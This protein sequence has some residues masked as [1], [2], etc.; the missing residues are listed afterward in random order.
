[1]NQT[2]A[3]WMP[4]PSTASLLCLSFP[5]ELIHSSKDLICKCYPER[6]V[7]EVLT[8]TPPSFT[9]LRLLV[10]QGSHP[11]LLRVVGVSGASHTPALGCTSRATLQAE[12]GL[13]TFRA[14]A[15]I[16]W[17]PQHSKGHGQK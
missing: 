3:L 11:L 9:F 7:P 15:W 17:P 6:G 10:L 2:W 16:F 5:Q 12:I 4:R 14:F 13:S 8:R 1:M